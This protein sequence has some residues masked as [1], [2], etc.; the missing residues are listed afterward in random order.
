MMLCLRECVYSVDKI[1]MWTET[2]AKN[3]IGAFK[4]CVR[5][6]DGNPGGS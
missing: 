5:K 6:S 3:I 1:S 4:A 2:V